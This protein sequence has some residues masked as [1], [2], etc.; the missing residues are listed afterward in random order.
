MRVV[1]D[2][3]RLIFTVPAY[4]IRLVAVSQPRQAAGRTSVRTFGGPSMNH[5]FRTF[6][7]MAYTLCLLTTRTVELIESA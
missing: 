3:V 7:S 4:I 1:S 6:V 2:V 5:H